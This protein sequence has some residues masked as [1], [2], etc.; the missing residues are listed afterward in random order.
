MGFVDVGSTFVFGQDFAD[1]FFAFKVL[2]TIIFFSAFMSVLYYLRVMQVAVQILGRLMQHTLGTTGPE[3]LAAAA[4]IFLGE[5][6]AP[7]MV[8]PYV[9]SMTRS[10]PMAIMV[11]GFGS[12]AGVLAAYVGMG[13]DA[14]HL[15]TASVLSAPASLL[16]AKIM[17]P[18]TEKPLAAEDAI[19]SVE[20]LGENLI[21]AIT[22]GATQGMKLAITVAAMLIAF[23]AL[24][25]M[26]DAT[27]GWI[28]TQFGHVVVLPRQDLFAPL[29]WLMG[30]EWAD[31]FRAG[32]PQFRTVTNEM[33][34]D[35]CMAE[36][37]NLRI[38]NPTQSPLASDPHLRPV[39]V[40]QFWLHR[41]S[42]RGHL[43]HGPRTT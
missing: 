28:G 22:I 14:A 12:T 27:L 29:A 8:R 21:E 6:E 16:I 5:I 11:P 24:I 43:L 19:V 18:E 31:C 33:V 2:P 36:W 26:C 23:L 38:R 40:C 3:S 10:E 41:R 15:V 30:V 39:R 9:R 17:V 34:A 42:T 4:N 20:D 7:L 32:D 25:T 13:I 37:L 1:H 35:E